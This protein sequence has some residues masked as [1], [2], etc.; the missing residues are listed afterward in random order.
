MSATS[1][2]KQGHEVIIREE[3][4]QKQK[5]KGKWKASGTR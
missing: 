2:Q 5:F 1:F 4:K 3:M